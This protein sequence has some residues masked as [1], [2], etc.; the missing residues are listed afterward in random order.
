MLFIAHYDMNINKL[1]HLSA[2]PELKHF[3][4]QNLQNLI[5]VNFL[6]LLLFPNTTVR[7]LS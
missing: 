3:S 5:S 1:T 7:Y 2:I 4:S 6:T